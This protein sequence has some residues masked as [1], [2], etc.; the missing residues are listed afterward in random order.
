M[1]EVAKG[2]CSLLNSPQHLEFRISLLR[3]LRV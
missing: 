2:L 3:L 1:H